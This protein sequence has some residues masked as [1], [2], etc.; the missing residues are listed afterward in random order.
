M[1]KKIKTPS[2]RTTA[3]LTMSPRH[4]RLLEQEVHKRT[5]LRQ[6]TDRI[7][8]L[9]LGNDGQSN[10]QIS[11]DLGVALNTVKVWRARW[12]SAL[13]ELL[14]LESAATDKPLSDF[15]LLQAMLKHLNDLPRSGTTKRITLAQEE[16]I[17]ALACS[18][19]TDHGLEMTTWTFA[20]LAQ[21]AISCG[22]IK[23]ISPR[24]VW[25]ILKKVQVTTA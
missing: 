12:V 16:Q 4:R 7:S 23:S 25:E 18:K 5:T 14:A 9:L 24:Y 19:P 6:Y 3:A 21:T 8:I 20:M 11:R 2:P 13:P 22:I 1:L 17:V 15:D 10:N